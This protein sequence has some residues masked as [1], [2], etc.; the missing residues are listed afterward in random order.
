MSRGI[1][2][3]VR[4]AVVWLLASAGAL[5]ACRLAAGSWATVR[6]PG[7]AIGPAAL[8]VAVCAAVLALA[9]AWLWVITTVTVV[10]VLTGRLRSG[11][12]ATRRLVLL[13]C[14][15]A[16]VAGVASP[17]TAGG[18]ERADVLA[19]LALPER[20]VAPGAPQAPGPDR[21]RDGAYV[22]R[23]GDS[24]WSVA[25]D[26]PAAGTTTDER[27]REIWRANRAVVGADPDLIHP[28]QALRLPVP[29]DGHQD[30]DR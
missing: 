23:A 12:G 2:R 21:H 20:A 1:V 7:A 15:A 24:L 29:T 14:G 26:H 17:A 8:L 9:L 28:G 6:G 4:S 11:G 16:V 30:G 19:G 27:W 5:G 18:G 22:V 3:T 13:A 25:R 10:E